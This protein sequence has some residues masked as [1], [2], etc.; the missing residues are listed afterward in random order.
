MERSTAATKN[1]YFSALMDIPVPAIL[2]RLFGFTPS[3]KNTKQNAAV[4]NI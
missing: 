1:S 2:F 4:V 3:E